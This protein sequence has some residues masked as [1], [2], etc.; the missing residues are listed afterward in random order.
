ME[1]K[2][3]EKGTRERKYLQN[4][5]LLKTVIQSIQR[6]LKTHHRVNNEAD[7]KIK[8]LNRDLTKEDIRMA[9]KFMKRCS[10]VVGHQGNAN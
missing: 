9:S 7:L 6:T 4:T 1:K 8:D 3:K 10:N 5:S 2:K